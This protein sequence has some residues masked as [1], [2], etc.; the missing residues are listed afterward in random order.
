MDTS[1][2]VVIAS[3]SLA[4]VIFYEGTVLVLPDHGS[5]AEVQCDATGSKFPLEANDPTLPVSP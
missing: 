2:R 4:L 5:T 1:M 3:G